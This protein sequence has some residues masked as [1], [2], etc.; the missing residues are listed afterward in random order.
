MRVVGRGQNAPCLIGRYVVLRFLIAGAVAGT[1]AGAFAGTVA[2]A[3]A[4]TVAV[5]VTGAV[6]VQS[7][8]QS[9]AQS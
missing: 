5:I 2:G 4:G 8:S 1:V 6:A 7:R 3:T 9:Q